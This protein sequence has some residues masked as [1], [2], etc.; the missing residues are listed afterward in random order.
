MLSVTF[1]GCDVGGMGE[2]DAEEK[3][4]RK[5]NEGLHG[6][7]EAE[8]ERRRRRPESTNL[9]V[10]VLDPKKYISRL[11]N[12]SQKNLGAREPLIA[13][14]IAESKAPAHPYIVGIGDGFQLELVSN[15]GRKK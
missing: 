9:C 1:D 6:V 15:N 2:F 5:P 13:V 14:V 8:R 3:E 4:S 12:S 11:C 10:F 7:V